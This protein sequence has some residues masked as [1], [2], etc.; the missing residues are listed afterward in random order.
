[1][2]GSRFRGDGLGM[3][4]PISTPYAQRAAR[5]LDVLLELLERRELSP[6]ELRV[7]LAVAGGE[8]SLAS[9]AETLQKPTR[10]VRRAA[11]RLYLAGMLRQRHD[12]AT[13]GPAFG[14]TTRGLAALKPLVTAAATR[15]GPTS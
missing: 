13:E 6:E 14:I 8:V 11:W 4:A 12:P 3:P 2:G 9:L 15:T 7:L 1:M 10:P 5:R